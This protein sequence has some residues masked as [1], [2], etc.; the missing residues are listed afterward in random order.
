MSKQ[1]EI[2]ELLKQGLAD[3]E[4]IGKGY[5]KNT[6]RLT[7]GKYEKS[8]KKTDMV[9]VP[10]GNST[11]GNP[12]GDTGNKP[13]NEDKKN[14]IE[15]EEPE[16]E[17]ETGIDEILD[18]GDGKHSFR[19][20]ISNFNI[21]RDSI[22]IPDDNDNKTPEKTAFTDI[23]SVF[24]KIFDIIAMITGKDYWHLSTEEQKGLKNLC[25]NKGLGKYAA[26]IDKYSC[27]IVFIE[28]VGKR[29]GKLF[30]ESKEKQK[31][32]EEKQPEASNDFMQKFSNRTGVTK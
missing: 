16:T 22:T 17:I 1:T 15:M 29:I 20:E 19:Q 10:G 8:L 11:D 3:D 31:I 7:R 23:S 32:A 26:E 9:G 13:D 25:K 27:W 5:N 21:N 6:V 4:I 2:I 12:A 30:K 14:D 18:K 28:I 24:T